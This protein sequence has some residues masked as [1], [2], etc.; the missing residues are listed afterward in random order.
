[1]TY[2]LEAERVGSDGPFFCQIA[3]N[4]SSISTQSEARPEWIEK[5][6]E[7]ERE[8]ERKREREK[9]REEERER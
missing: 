5:E 3:P 1:V 4:Q 8:R 9:E 7:R 2:S 6:R